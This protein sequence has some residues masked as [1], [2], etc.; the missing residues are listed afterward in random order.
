MYPLV[1]YIA[2]VIGVTGSWFLLGI[3]LFAAAV[4]IREKLTRSEQ[5]F[6]YN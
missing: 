4:I 3:I 1:G 2:D 6:I 5:R